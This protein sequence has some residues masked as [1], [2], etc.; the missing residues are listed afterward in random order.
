IVDE[1]AESTLRRWASREV[2]GE[3]RFLAIAEAADRDPWRREVRTMISRGD[4]AALR[5]LS[6]GLDDDKATTRGILNLAAALTY[7]GE[8]PRALALLRA[9]QHRHPD[10][11]WVN[12]NLAL[13]LIN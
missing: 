13:A 6:E 7:K 8:Y 4:V 2:E 12:F 3:R 10:D 11:Y 5:K 1:L 9:L